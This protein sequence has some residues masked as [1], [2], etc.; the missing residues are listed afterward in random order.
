[1]FRSLLV[2]NRGEVAVRIARAARDA[3]VRTVGVVSTADQGAPWTGAFDEVVCIGGPAPAESYLR[4]SAI[5]QAARQTGCAAVH[6]GWGFLA[7]NARFAA[8][9]EQNGLTFVGPAPSTMERMGLKWPSKVAMRA[10]GLD[11]TPGSDG[12]LE[13]VDEA[14]RVASDVGYPVILKADAGGGGR[15][16]R[17]C[18]NEADVREAYPSARAEA[19]AAFGNG[20]LFLE[21]FVTGGRHIEV[22]IIG[23][24][25]GRAVHLFE[26]DCSV[27]R[28]HQK[29]IEESPSPAL[30][31][32]ERAELGARAAQA[33]EAIGYVGAGTIEFLAAPGSGRLSFMEMNTRLQVEHPV[34]EMVTGIDI[35]REQLRIAAGGPVG[36][37]QEGVALEGH[38]IECRINAEDPSDGF[39]PTPG[40]LEEFDIPLDLGPGRVRVD[41]HVEAG[42][43]VP[44]YYDSLIAKVIVHAADRDQAIETMKRTL[45]GARI[46]GV[47][48][49]IPLHLAVLGS[50]EFMSGNYDTRSIPGWPA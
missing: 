39:R 44:P 23:D 12:L 8:L 5:V 21:K 46:T 50:E 32:E 7:E 48:T 22:Q 1:M 2:A 41:T 30:S 13:D 20:A 6:P 9:C 40:T 18:R 11:L 31:A 42:A 37:T 47:S 4:M 25:F 14:V 28:N 27:Q 26:R 33:A 35:V 3:G 17:I 34:T 49:T 16:M 38:S 36:F 43:E 10:A 19:V 29:L 24:Q 15:G 45:D